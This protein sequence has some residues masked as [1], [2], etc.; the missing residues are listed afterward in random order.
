MG[1]PDT[2]Y[3]NQ[4]LAG[5]ESLRILLSRFRQLLVAKRSPT[6][7]FLSGQVFSLSLGANSKRVTGKSH[8][9][10]ALI[11]GVPVLCCGRSHP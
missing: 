10:A 5:S 3:G 6:P 7:M 11:H 1:S 2:K 4:G 9:A 8:R